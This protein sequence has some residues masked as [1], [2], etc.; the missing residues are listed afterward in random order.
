MI[1]NDVITVTIAVPVTNVSIEL[2]TLELIPRMKT[3][4]V[5]AENI[6]K[7]AGIHMWYPRE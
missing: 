5:S 6:V 4:Q 1:I 7:S 2:S 3:W